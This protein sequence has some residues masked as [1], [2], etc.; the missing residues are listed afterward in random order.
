MPSRAEEREEISSNRIYNTYNIAELQVF[1][2]VFSSFL[3]SWVQSFLI[4]SSLLISWVQSIGIRAR[5]ATSTGRL[6]CAHCLE[7][8]AHTAQGECLFHFLVWFYITVCCLLFGNIGGSFLPHCYFVYLL[9]FR[10]STYSSRCFSDLFF[11]LCVYFLFVFF[12]FVSVKYFCYLFVFHFHF[13][14]LKCFF[15]YLISCPGK[16]DRHI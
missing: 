3:I 15:L 4:V 7:T 11:A 1:S 5:S 6:W 2:F 12:A 13:F 10:D 16:R 8:Q 9:I 14:G